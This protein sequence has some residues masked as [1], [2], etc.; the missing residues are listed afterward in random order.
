M[1]CQ[2]SKTGCHHARQMPSLLCYYCLNLKLGFVL[3]KFGFKQSFRPTTSPISRCE[4]QTLLADFRK[5][6]PWRLMHCPQGNQRLPCTGH[7]TCQVVI[8]CAGTFLQTQRHKMQ[9]PRMP[10]CL[11]E[12]FS[13]S[14]PP[15]GAAESISHPSSEGSSRESVLEGREAG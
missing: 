9:L 2:G 6:A 7:G 3:T 4:T 5:P 15:A 8:C 1:E 13:M 11:Q 12:E 14:L 10:A